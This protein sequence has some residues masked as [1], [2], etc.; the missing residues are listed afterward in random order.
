MIWPSL[1]M[2]TLIDV[3]IGFS[4]SLCVSVFYKKNALLKSEASEWYVIGRFLNVLFVVTDNMEE[5]FLNEMIM[6]NVVGCK[7]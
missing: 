5:L 3:F 7:E 2:I 6:T 4:Y 1:L